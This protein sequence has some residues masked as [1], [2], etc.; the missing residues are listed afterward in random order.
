[1]PIYIAGH[2]LLVSLVVL[3]YIYAIGS[4][5]SPLLAMLASLAAIYIVYAL[6]APLVVISNSRIQVT[7]L[8]KVKKAAGPYADGFLGVK[9]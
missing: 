2:G 5:R 8:K 1:M 4:L 6:L 7:G 3:L 9:G